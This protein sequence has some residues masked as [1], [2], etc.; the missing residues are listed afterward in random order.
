LTGLWPQDVAESAHYLL[1]LKEIERS[2]LRQEINYRN[3]LAICELDKVG[4]EKKDK[5]SGALIR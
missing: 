1:H 5:P 4:T 2:R 3:F